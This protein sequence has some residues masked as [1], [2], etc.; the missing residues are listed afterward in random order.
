M[1]SGR[2]KLKQSK[3]KEKHEISR[4]HS[5]SIVMDAVHIVGLYNLADRRMSEKSLL[6]CLQALVEYNSQRR[7]QSLDL[8]D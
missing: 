1:A 5:R 6:S 8:I 7:Q 3:E 4:Q 2:L